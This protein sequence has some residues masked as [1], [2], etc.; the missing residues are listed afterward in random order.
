[1][2]EHIVGQSALPPIPADLALS[3]LFLM[4]LYLDM[5]DNCP[6]SAMYSFI[7]SRVAKAG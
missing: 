7:G 3:L 1:M 6:V 5:Q 2:I 4:G